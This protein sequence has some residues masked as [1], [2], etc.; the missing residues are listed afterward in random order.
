LGGNRKQGRHSRLRAIAA[1]L[2]IAAS[3]VSIAACGSESSSDVNEPG[4]HYQVKVVKAEFPT[5]QRLGQTSLLRIGVRNSGEKKVPALTM[6]LSIAG[7]EGQ[8]SSLPFGIH[9][10][11]PGLAQPDRPAW[12]LSENYP[13]VGDSSEPGGVT[14]ASPKTFDFGPLKPGASVE[15]VW[16]VSAV[17]TGRYTV[18]Y[19]VNAGLLGAA[20]AETAGGVKPG[21]SFAV[22]ISSVPPNTI[23]TDSG[24]VVEIP[25]RKHRGE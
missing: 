13:K 23:V 16:K 15:G 20:K 1:G 17:K 6:T 24:E 10:P 21:G 2:A 9:S 25:Q 14:T 3:T 22:Q 4:G 11:E 5:R 8:T 12:V 18:L 7:K 19:E